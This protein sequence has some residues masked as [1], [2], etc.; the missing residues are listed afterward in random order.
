AEDI[1]VAVQLVDIAAAGYQRPDVAA[2]HLPPT[3]VDAAVNGA[4]GVQH[5]DVATAIG[6][7]HQDSRGAHS[8]GRTACIIM[9][10]ILVGNGDGDLAGPLAGI[11][12]RAPHLEATTRSSLDLPR[13]RRSI[14]PVDHSEVP[15]WPARD[16][17]GV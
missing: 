8:G 10:R 9:T 15:G 1:V 14:T 2:G 13:S 6:N 7:R 11:A 12:V 3:T 17:V 4:V 5:V 16:G